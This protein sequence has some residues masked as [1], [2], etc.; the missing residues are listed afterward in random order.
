[1]LWKFDANRP[2]YLQIKE[3][4]RSAVLSGQ[5]PPGSRI[6]SVRELAVTAKVNPNTMQ[7]AMAELEQEGLLVSSGTL[8]KFVT[9]DQTIV[10]AIR[11]K[12]VTDAIAAAAA[13]FRELGLSMEDAA[14]L[15]TKQEEV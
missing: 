2:V 8:G 12:A 4:F 13:R 7:R 10:K 1:M 6:P 5:Y 11:Q 15:L 9:E 14:A 3:Q